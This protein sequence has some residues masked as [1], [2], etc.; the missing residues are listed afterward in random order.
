MAIEPVQLNRRDIER[1]FRTEVDLGHFRLADRAVIP[2][3][4][5]ESLLSASRRIA[6][7]LLHEDEVVDRL[8]REEIVVAD[9]MQH[10][11]LQFQKPRGEV[12]ARPEPVRLGVREVGIEP[13]HRPADRIV[14]IAEWQPQERIVHVG[15]CDAVGLRRV[16]RNPSGD[17]GQPHRATQIEVPVKAAPGGLRRDRDQPR[18]IFDSRL[19]LHCTDIRTSDHPNASVAPRLPGN[20][21]DGVEPVLPIVVVGGQHTFG[22]PCAAAVL[23]HEDISRLNPALGGR[24]LFRAI[25]GGANQHDGSPVSSVT[26]IDVRREFHAVAH[27][28]ADGLVRDVTERRM[29]Q[30]EREENGE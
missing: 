17:Q 28:N 14:D 15:G 21:F 29:A 8:T 7:V 10:G 22:R 6:S 27:R 23:S 25:I 16:A 5:D 9:D 4:E 24:F 30:G 3:S 11:Q 13:R 2:R 18:R 20:P 26:A 1:R 19:P 12:E